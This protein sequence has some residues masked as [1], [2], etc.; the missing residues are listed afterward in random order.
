MKKLILII[1]KITFISCVED[2]LNIEKVNYSEDLKVEK[3]HKYVDDIILSPHAMVNVDNEYIII[4]EF[5]N[6]NFFN[7]FKLPDL[8][9]LYSWGKISSGPETE[10]FQSLPVNL[11]EL[12]GNLIVYDAVSRNLKHINVTDSTVNTIKTESLYYNNQL[13]PLN[14]LN[15]FDES[16]YIADYGLSREA[17]DHEYIALEPNNSIPLFT[18]SNY[19]DS[20]LEA[21]ER[22]DEFL[23]SNVTNSSRNRLAAFYFYHDMLKIFDQKGNVL[24]FIK[25]DDPFNDRQEE[26]DNYIYRVASKSE[27][28]NYIFTL[29]FHT[30]RNKVFDS[31]GEDAVKTSFEVWDWNGNSIYRAYFDRKI[32]NFVVI[33]EI[34]KIFGVSNI[35]EGTIYEYLLPVNLKVK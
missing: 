31:A 6:E 13:E 16:I 7:V 26:A 12:N 33:E 22:Y 2:K 19:P 5:R 1:I 25:I 28:D 21:I 30:N 27:S 15:A 17:T 14:R 8:V 29:G 3:I 23:K 35:K 11:F 34:N 18:F 32:I 4:S 24:E 20:D 9:H 10:E